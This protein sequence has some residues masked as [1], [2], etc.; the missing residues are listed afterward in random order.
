L[1][2]ANHLDIAVAGAGQ[3][4]P[5]AG[6]RNRACPVLSRPAVPDPPLVAMAR[7]RDL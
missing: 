7:Y 6:D 2:V 3:A 4:V 1:I 5:G